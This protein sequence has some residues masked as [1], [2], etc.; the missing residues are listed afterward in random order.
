MDWVKGTDFSKYKTYA[1]GTSHLMTPQKHP[2]EDIDAALQA[3]GLHR[4]GRNE[5]P[6]LLVAFSSGT[7]PVYVIEGF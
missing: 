6:S 5:N 3:E 7:K 1:W 2:T 4:V